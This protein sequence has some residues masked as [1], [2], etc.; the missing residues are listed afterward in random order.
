ML[1]KHGDEG[2][3]PGL[4]LLSATVDRTFSEGCSRQFCWRYL[5]EAHLDAI[6]NALDFLNDSIGEGKRLLPEGL[7][8]LFFLPT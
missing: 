3:L 2:A 6:C 1:E 8:L 7:K 5:L 4:E